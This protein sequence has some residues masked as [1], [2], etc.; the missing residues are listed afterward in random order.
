MKDSPLRPVLEQVLD[1]A[2]A[3]LNNLDRKP[4]ASTV[5]LATLRSRLGKPLNDAGLPP[6]TVVAEL[7][8]DVEG[9]VLGSAG[10]RFFGWVIGGTE[11]AALAADWLTS[12]WDQ[13]AAL[14]ACSPAASV[15]EEVVGG[16][17][18]QILGLPVTASFALVT[19]A[20]M[21]HFTCLAAARNALLARRGW[22]VE[23]RG[24]Y[25]APPIRILLSNQY[26]GSIE[27]A[28]RHLGLG[29]SQMVNVATDYAGRVLP[30]ALEA[31]L[32]DASLFP[33]I[34]IL[35]AGDICTG[36]FDDFA[37]LIPLASQRGAWVHVDGAFG[38]WACASPKYR[39]LARQV[40][41]ADSWTT[42]GHKWLNVP[43]DCGYAFVADAEAHRNSMAHRAAYLTHDKHA[44][45][46]MDWNPEWSRRAR[47]FPTYAAL[48]QLG[49]SG[50]AD[51][52]ER[53]CKH[54]EV[55]V[56]RLATLRGVEVL[57]PPS[58]NQALVGFLDSTPNASEK[59]HD[60]KT[61]E[62]IAAVAASGEAFFT[63][64]TWHGRRAMRVSVCNWKT[65]D[66]DVD[67]AVSAT[68]HALELD[69]KQ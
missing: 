6:E 47:G 10:G 53:S 27:R 22:D 55:M 8:K 37:T 62:V 35:Q 1:I 56:S 2:L 43:Y 3:Y 34:V 64:T 45:D 29:K 24:L 33:T 15:I 28:I 50:V 11:P 30:A 26:H 21:S 57:S 52:I 9:A 31:A 17:L 4:V 67:R 58:L 49:R 40:E 48:R 68:A 7:A 66:R 60:R 51:L 59:D 46:Q 36:A 61:D 41:L 25:G 65:S 69:H 54:A 18:K 16:W 5:D 38:L 39:G 14:Y 19:G 13:N 44:R 23:D 12:A 63:G 32:K 20:Q 42:D